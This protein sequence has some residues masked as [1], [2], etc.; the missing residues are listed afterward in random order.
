ME[1]IDNIKA[2]WDE[3]DEVDRRKFWWAVF[4]IIVAL[5]AIYK[6]I[7][8]LGFAGDFIGRGVE[9]ANQTLADTG[10]ILD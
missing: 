2:K 7:D 1:L 6:V 4:M 8:F 10:A 3:M 5:I 9:Y